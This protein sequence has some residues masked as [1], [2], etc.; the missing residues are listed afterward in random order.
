MPNC[1]CEGVH[2]KVSPLLQV[3]WKRLVLDEGHV[4]AT[5][6]TSLTSFAR[7]LSVER[8]WIVTG[9]PTTNLLGLS[10]GR[11]AQTGGL[12]EE[13]SGEWGPQ[14]PGEKSAM[15]GV[16]GLEPDVI[17]PAVPT[18]S[19]ISKEEGANGLQPRRWTRYDGEDLRKFSNMISYFLGVPQYA[20]DPRTFYNIVKAPLLEPSGPAPGSIQV[21]EQVMQSYMYRHR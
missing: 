19:E 18:S 21:L 9:T 16:D 12:D 10:F 1:S 2:P 20:A 8:R 14:G 7:K 17:D 11:G 5:M 13:P 6:N 3:R 4:A 15:K